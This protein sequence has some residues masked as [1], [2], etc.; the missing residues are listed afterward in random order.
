MEKYNLDDKGGLFKFVEKRPAKVVKSGDNI[1]LKHFSFLGSLNA[2][3]LEVGESTIRIELK[4]KS[5]DF[6]PSPGDPVVLNYK[7]SNDVFVVTAEIASIDKTDP[8]QLSIKVSKIEKYKDLVKEKKY[9]VAFPA[10]IKI[11]GVPESKFAAV[12]NISFGGIKVNCRED[13]MLE[14]IVDATVSIDKANKISFKGR[15]VRKNKLQD[16]FEYGIEYTEMTD[17][18][19]KLLTRLMYEFETKV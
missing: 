7:P 13:I 16:C 11:I 15:I 10:Q 17:T 19:S 5:A 12:K 9:C 4:E 3:I 1:E 6:N 2:S 14:D 8:I 18:N